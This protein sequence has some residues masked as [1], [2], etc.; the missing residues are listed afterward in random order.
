MVKCSGDE[1][2]SLGSLSSSSLPEDKDFSE[3]CFS[4]YSKQLGW[5]FPLVTLL[6]RATV[7][8][9]SCQSLTKEKQEG[10]ALVA[11]Y[12]KSDFIFLR[13]IHSF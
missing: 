9:H 5:E 12:K 10:L 2:A 4:T 13:V 11:L 1:K 8:N 6:K 7:A 3:V